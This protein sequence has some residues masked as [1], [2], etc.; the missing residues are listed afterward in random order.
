MS[1]LE[2]G[3]N[4]D[5]KYEVLARVRGGGMGEVY[6]VRHVH[7]HETRIIKLLR[8]GLEAQSDAAE[9][10]HREARLATQVKHPRVATLHDYSRLSDGSFYMVWEYIEGQ[11][12]ESWLREKGVFPIA[13]ALELGIQGLSGLEAIHRAGIVHRDL[14]PDNLMITSDRRGRLGV[15]IIDLGLARDTE[16]PGLIESQEKAFGGK[17]NYCSPEHVGLIEGVRPDRLSD[18]YSFAIVLYKMFSGR[19][20]FEEIGP[21]VSLSSRFEHEPYP[22]VGRNPEVAVPEELWAVLRKALSFRR[23]DRYP[24]ASSFREALQDIHGSD[25]AARGG[26][27]DARAPAAPPAEEAN[28]VIEELKRRVEHAETQKR[29]FQ[30]MQA[31]ELVEQYLG[32]G[33]QALARLSL[34][35]LLELDPEHPERVSLEERIS[36]LSK[37]R[38]RRDDLEQVER[39]VEAA[40]ARGEFVRAREAIAAVQGRDLRLAE[41]LHRRVEVAEQHRQLDDQVTFHRGRLDQF[42]AREQLAEAELELTLVEALDMPRVVVDLYRRRIESLRAQ[43]DRVQQSRAVE[44]RL[45]GELEAG[46]FHDARESLLEL[47]N[48]DV[49]PG[50][51]MDL[52]RRIDRRE[53]KALRRSAVAEGVQALRGFLAAGELDQ[54]ELALRV[55]E[56]MAPDDPEATALGVELRARKTTPSPNSP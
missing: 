5:G 36:L 54:A 30:S 23:E 37:E 45:E 35:T 41:R 18:L 15:K 43:M 39:D 31:R 49:E 9:R 1:R 47:E 25:R 28:T 8:A 14:S 24:A 13:I 17:L 21:G 51:V 6:R 2:I 38:E 11:D 4:L 46:V 29:H 53:E 44:R 32:A 50:R 55:L 40:V 3:S 12:V 33:H 42:L 34:E 20:P 56:R 27:P 19:L 52:R 48:L 10:F 22:L 7:L 16:D 26:Q